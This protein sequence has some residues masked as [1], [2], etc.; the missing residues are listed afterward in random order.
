MSAAPQVSSLIAALGDGR[1]GLRHFA[2][3]RLV[4]LGVGAVPALIASL[5]TKNDTM[6]EAAAMHW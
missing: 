6:Q 5:K 4:A 2:I 3:R 1:E